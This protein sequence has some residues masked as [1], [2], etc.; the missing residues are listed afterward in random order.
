MAWHYWGLAGGYLKQNN[1]EAEHITALSEPSSVVVPE[2]TATRSSRE[3]LHTSSYASLQLRYMRVHKTQHQTSLIL[4]N[5]KTARK[6][7]HVA[8]I[9]A[10]FTSFLSF[11]THSKISYMEK[12]QNVNII[13][14]ER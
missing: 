7:N 11:S 1:S 10:S 5:K 14:R 2:E 6:G 8:C 9:K 3:T 13:H 12:Y 4:L